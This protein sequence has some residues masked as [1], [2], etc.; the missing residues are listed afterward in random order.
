MFVGPSVFLFYFIIFICI[1]IFFIF[2]YVSK[3]LFLFE[4][5]LIRKTSYKSVILYSIVFFSNFLIYCNFFLFSIIPF[6]LLILL[7]LVSCQ[8]LCFHKT[9]IWEKNSDKLYIFRL[10]SLPMFVLL[11]LNFHFFYLHCKFSFLLAVVS[12]Q[13][14]VSIR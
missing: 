6:F 10:Y 3:S 11:F 7:A 5:H 13:F 8:Y 4:N 1:F 2:Q 9:I 14:L 12:C